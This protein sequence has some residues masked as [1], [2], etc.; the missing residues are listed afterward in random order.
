MTDRHSRPR[1]P[2]VSLLFD[3]DETL[4]THSMETIPAVW[5]LSSDE[6]K[7]RFV[8]PLGSGWDEIPKH[9][10]AFVHA[11][12]AMD[13][14]MSRDVLEAAAEKT[15]LF[16]GAAAMPARLREVARGVDE[17]I[18][19][20]FCVLSSGFH[21]LIAATPIADAFDRIYASTYHFDE[22]GLAVCIKRAVTHSG[23]ALYLEA[24]GKGL[25]EGGDVAD[26][27]MR[28]ARPVPMEEWRTP[29]DQ[30]IYCG[31]GESDLQAFAFLEGAGGQSIAVDGGEGFAPDDQSAAERPRAIV[32]PSY[33]QGG[34][35]MKVLENAVLSAAYR[36]TTA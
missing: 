2:R 5:G 30:M 22:E 23:K 6:F 27:H 36:A 35:T 28:A 31:D 21:E 33:A 10:L 25:L 4:A 14:P 7:Q 20:E 16:D 29:F 8:E 13:R 1:I 15:T 12:R 19:L 9:G 18:E 3:F 26:L 11:G 24:Y 17:G 32:E 34:P